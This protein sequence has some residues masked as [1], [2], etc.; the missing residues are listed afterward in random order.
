MTLEDIEDA[1]CYDDLVTIFAHFKVLIPRY[2]CRQAKVAQGVVSKEFMR[3]T[4]ILEF[5]KKCAH[6]SYTWYSLVK[7]LELICQTCA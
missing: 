3:M 5:Q 1:V 2:V 7:I 4:Q 6:K